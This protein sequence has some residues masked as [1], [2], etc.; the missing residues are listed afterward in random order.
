MDMH[1][2]FGNIFKVSLSHHITFN[3]LEHIQLKITVSVS[4]RNHV[5]NV[6]IDTITIILYCTVGSQIPRSSSVVFIK[7]KK[8]PHVN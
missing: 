1:V 4:G 2:V 7:I 3:T 6:A 8:N 5:D